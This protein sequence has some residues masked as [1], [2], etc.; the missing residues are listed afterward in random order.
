M[1]KLKNVIIS[2]VFI[3]ISSSN[4]FNACNKIIECMDMPIIKRKIKTDDIFVFICKESRNK[5]VKSKGKLK[6]VNLKPF[7]K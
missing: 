2:L 3:T 4:Y 7:R 5:L 1:N 6:I